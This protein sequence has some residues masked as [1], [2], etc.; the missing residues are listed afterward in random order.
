[1]LYFTL[2][3][4]RHLDKQIHL[5]IP[6]LLELCIIHFSNAK[7][8][9]MKLASGKNTFVILNI[10]NSISLFIFAQPSTLKPYSVPVIR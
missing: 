8:P 2:E 4:F 7:L 1:M 10:R 3:V 5:H 9:N 6:V